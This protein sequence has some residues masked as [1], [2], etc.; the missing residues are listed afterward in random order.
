MTPPC[1]PGERCGACVRA[2]AETDDTARRAVLDLAYAYHRAHGWLPDDEQ[3]RP[4]L[5]EE[6]CVPCKRA[7]VALDPH[8]RAWLWVAVSRHGLY[9]WIPD[10]LMEMTS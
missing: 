8:S 2:A 6:R 9:G 3:R 5:P 10:S 1:I 7:A 4:C